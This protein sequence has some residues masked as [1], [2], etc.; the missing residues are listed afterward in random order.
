MRC[1]CRSDLHLMDTSAHI[2]SQE[3]LPLDAGGHTISGKMVDFA[4]TLEPT[5][6]MKIAFRHTKPI[7]PGRPQSFN[8]TDHLPIA[9][10]PIAVSIETKQSGE[11]QQAA[12]GQ[13]STWLLAQYQRLRYLTEEAGNKDAEMLLSPVMVVQGPTWSLLAAKQNEEGE[14]ILWDC[15]TFGESKSRLGVCQILATLLLLMR[16]SHEEYRAWFEKHVLCNPK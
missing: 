16:W 14:I 10:R 3:L 5:K 12:Y 1:C 8:Q 13:L 15:G 9:N 7:V 11:G 4:I 6:E 2:S